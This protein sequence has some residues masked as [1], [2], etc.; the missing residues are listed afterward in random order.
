MCHPSWERDSR[1]MEG[2]GPEQGHRL[3]LRVLR[4]P[5]HPCWPCTAPPG[6]SPGSGGPAAC[7]LGGNR[8]GPFSGILRNLAQPR[9]DLPQP[10]AEAGLG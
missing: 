5:P 3:E 2:V 9:A 4:L 8:V 10:L 1:A 7:D 6:T